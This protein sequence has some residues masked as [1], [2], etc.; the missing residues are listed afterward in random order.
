VNDLLNVD[1]DAL[2]MLNMSATQELIKK[3]TALEKEN[4]ALKE[5]NT[6]LKNAKADASDVLQ[7]KQDNISLQQQIDEL[8]KMMLTNAI[9]SQVESK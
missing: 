8:R 2:S 7:L 5:D 4:K 9:K 3:V 1:Y 6:L